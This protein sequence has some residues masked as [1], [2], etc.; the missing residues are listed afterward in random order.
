MKL[1]YVIIQCGDFREYAVTL[2]KGCVTKTRYFDVEQLALEFYQQI[3]DI[4]ESPDA[5]EQFDMIVLSHVLRQN[6]RIRHRIQLPDGSSSTWNGR[7]K[8]QCIHREGECY[9]FEAFIS[10]HYKEV[11]QQ[12]YTDAMQD[13][14]AMMHGKWIPIEDLR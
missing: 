11:P 3:R 2:E 8:D 12:E 1:F 5:F 7:F 13:C 10:A 9:K 14:D 4:Y 6:Q